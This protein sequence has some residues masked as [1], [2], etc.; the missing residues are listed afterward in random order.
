LR[1]PSG[2]ALSSRNLRLSVEERKSAAVIYRALSTAKSADE[3]R[4]LLSAEPAF[5]IDYAEFIDPRDFT[6][7]K[8]ES[9][10][11]RAIVAGW[12]NDIRLIDNIKIDNLQK[13]ELK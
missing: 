12:I 9:K 5:T 4:T 2:L 3:L 7:A 8:S 1:E 10:E 6:H 11:V 13:G